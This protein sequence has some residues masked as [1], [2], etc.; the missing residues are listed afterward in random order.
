MAH[1]SVSF[2]HPVLG[3]R[4]DMEGELEILE[5]SSFALESEVVRI[6]L[7]IHLEQPDLRSKLASGEALWI[8]T[9]DCQRTVLLCGYIVDHAEGPDGQPHLEIEIGRGDI[10]D[11]VTFLVEII[12]ADTLKDYSSGSF[13]ADYANFDFQIDPAQILGQSAPAVIQVDQ[14][15]D[16]LNPPTSSFLR[17]DR[18][19]DDLP[20][21]IHV[22]FD[23]DE[24]IVTVNGKLFDSIEQLPAMIRE[25][26]AISTVVMP[27]LVHVLTQTGATWQEGPDSRAELEQLRWFGGIRSKLEALRIVDADPVEQAYRILEAAPERFSQQLTRLADQEDAL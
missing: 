2:P 14:D 23:S 27:A 13:H 7:D 18:A 9:V 5:T 17:I 4:D 16:P 11:K 12:A 15:W 1:K 3:N 26:F 8:V 19:S 10:A 6:S 25:T 24:I 20:R 22:A 21:K